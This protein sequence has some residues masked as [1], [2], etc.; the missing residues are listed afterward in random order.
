M[1]LIS[2]GRAPPRRVVGIRADR[3]SEWRAQPGC[4]IIL[5]PSS[6]ETTSLEVP[7]ESLVCG[8]ISAPPVPLG[9]ARS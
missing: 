9:I 2:P 8:W 4:G 6:D 1:L 5:P 3:S 7:V